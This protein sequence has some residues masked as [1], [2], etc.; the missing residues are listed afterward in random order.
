MIRKQKQN[1][2]KKKLKKKRKAVIKA[3]KRG[4]A[5]TFNKK[6]NLKNRK[7]GQTR[8]MT[9]RS[10]PAV[11]QA[12]IEKQEMIESSRGVAKDKRLELSVSFLDELNKK[13]EENKGGSGISIGE[14]IIPTNIS[15][16]S[17]KQ[18][19]QPN[20]ASLVELALLRSLILLDEKVQPQVFA[21]DEKLKMNIADNI[22][23]FKNVVGETKKYND[24]AGLDNRELNILVLEL[25]AI[26]NTEVNKEVVN[27]GYMEKL[28]NYL[29]PG[30]TAYITKEV[31]N[32]LE[33]A[34]RAFDVFYAAADER[35]DDKT[36]KSSM[37]NEIMYAIGLGKVNIFE[38][39]ESPFISD[40]ITATSIKPAPQKDTMDNEA[41]RKREIF[42]EYSKAYTKL[43]NVSS[44]PIRQ[45]KAFYSRA[46][47]FITAAENR[48]LLKTAGAIVAATVIGATLGKD[49]YNAKKLM[50][51]T[52]G[53]WKDAVKMGARH[54]AGRAMGLGES[55]W[56]GAKNT[57]RKMKSAWE[58]RP[59]LQDIAE[60]PGQK[61]REWQWNRAQR[62][63]E[64]SEE[65]DF[66]SRAV[67][68][69]EYFGGESSGYNQKP[70]ILGRARKKIKSAW[71]NRPSVEAIT[72]KFK[73]NSELKG[74]RSKK[75]Y[76]EKIQ[77][78][79]DARDEYEKEYDNQRKSYEAKRRQEL[80]TQET[81]DRINKAI[82][83]MRMMDPYLT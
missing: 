74:P 59:S 48:G 78:Q 38:P 17:F 46:K 9:F 71:E 36:I 42:K 23:Q 12:L 76:I 67:T 8:V 4:K 24:L 7:K 14:Y 69:E 29:R 35:L 50:N 54:T 81:K 79:K 22:T 56:E 26:Y 45:V 75:E 20:I 28:K 40:M 60:K 2:Y 41:E 62:K 1:Q 6:R 49:I 25:I 72:S 57:G 31:N 58:N 43:A 39:L 52:D 61:Y 47:Q 83:S 33:K 44:Y 73:R 32:G 27:R 80:T 68:H 66:D 10:I 11:A 37:I 53:T 65:A 70:S 30:E 16:N 13:I 82:E 64:E 3:K 55:A 19:I 15:E 18:I 5:G 21:Q 77:K 34:K 51:E 63:S